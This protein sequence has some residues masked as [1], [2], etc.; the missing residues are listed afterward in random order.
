MAFILV[1]LLPS[2]TSAL[3]T[4]YSRNGEAVDY[5]PCN[6]SATGLAGSHTS[7]CLAGN[8]ICLASGLCMVSSQLPNDYAIVHADGCTDKTLQDSS[9]QTFCPKSTTAT[10][11]SVLKCPGYTWCCVDGFTTNASACCGGPTFTL[12]NGLGLAINQTTLMLTATAS[13]TA[14]VT[15]T[16]NSNNN[17]AVT[18]VGSV[19]GI[20]LAIS[21][22]VIAFLGWKVR[23][24]QSGS[25]GASTTLPTAAGQEEWKKIAAE[26]AGSGPDELPE[27]RG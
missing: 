8:D 25:V 5:T 14:T 15:A 2:I 4:C 13:A 26:P 9:C 19:L 12:P 21:V 1:F 17:A 7:C 18:A 16:S 6:I 3:A 27:L 23:R 11:Q 20:L 24:L 10:F 22:C